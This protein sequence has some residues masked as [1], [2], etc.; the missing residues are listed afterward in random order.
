MHV[1]QVILLATLS[2]SLAQIMT[3]LSCVGQSCILGTSFVD[4]ALVID[5][6]TSIDRP[7]FEA[8]KSF[9][10]LWASD[11]SIG[12]NPNQVQFGFVTYGLWAASYGTFSTASTTID[13]LN[14]VVADLAYQPHNDRNMFDALTKVSNNLLSTDLNSGWRPNARHLMVVFS[15]DSFTGP[16]TWKNVASTLRPQFDRVVAVGLTQK[17]ITNQYLELVEIVDGDISNVFLIGGPTELKYIIPWLE[18]QVCDV[19]SNSAQS[20]TP[21]PTT[22]ASTPAPTTVPASCQHM[23]ILFLIDE[24][25][26]M[27]ISDGIGSAKS[28]VLNVTD[29]YKVIPDV[30][31]AWIVFNSEVWVQTAFMAAQDFKTNV[32]NTNFN[33]G[34]TNFVLGFNAASYTISTYSD[35]SQQRQPILIFVSDGNLNDGGG[36]SQVTA[37]TT[38]LRCNL[39]TRIIG[40]GVNEALTD[41]QTMRD[42]IGVGA[43]D[44]CTVSHYS[45]ISNYAQIPI[46]GLTQVEQDLQCRPTK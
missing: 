7:Y 16:A 23:D 10:S 35:P 2:G 13:T 18:F 44:N 11:Y 12:T 41:A 9:I 8:I 25:Q 4:I 14:S 46:A 31:F 21:P 29:T 30:R 5:T 15:G 26:S 33:E 3:N 39:N 34:S 28:F 36:L 19:S 43:Q 42:A 45:D 1:A 20:S 17:A 38:Y 22:L 37:F 27:H 6:S 24:S 32:M 40:L